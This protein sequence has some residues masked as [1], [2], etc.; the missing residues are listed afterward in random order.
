MKLSGSA[1]V[2]LGAPVAATLFI[3]FPELDLITSA[4]LHRPDGFILKGNA[5]FDFVHAYVGVPAW[6][7]AIAAVTVALAASRSVRLLPWRKPV[8]YVLLVLLVGPGI[9]VNGIFKEHW[10][11][12]RPVHLDEFGGERQFTPAWIVSD[13]CAGNCSFV[14]GDASIGFSL[15]ALAF[16]SR[17]PARWLLGA[18]VLGGGLGLMRM[19]QGGHFLSDVVFS[20]YAV[21]FT[22]WLLHRA[23]GRPR[24][25]AP[26][27]QQ[28]D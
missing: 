8:V 3:A 11:R 25:P 26:V 20:F 28:Y 21:W 22:A 14:C 18:V 4:A 19:A 23:M 27:A 24:L 13:Q 10:G 5:L 9:L 2:A 15:V 1:T 16:L 7:V 17:R 12:A 6:L